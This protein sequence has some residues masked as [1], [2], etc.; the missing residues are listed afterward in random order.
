VKFGLFYEHQLP[1]P[2]T[3]DAEH[4]LLK[5]A[6][7]QVELADQLGF[8]Q[9][10]EVEHHFLEEYSHSSAPE[11]FLAAASQRTSRIRLGH[12][13]IQTPPPFNHPARVA[14]RV[15]TLDLL[16]D[17]RV[18][19]G[20]GESS[21]EAEL[22]G[23]G[24]HPMD[25]RDMWREG[26]DVAV[27]CLTE[28]PFT[29]HHGKHVQMPPRNVVPKPMQKPHPPLW[30]ACSR[31]DTIRLAAELGIGA[32][33]F[34][35]IDPEDAAH[36]ATEYEQILADRCVPAGLA[37]NHQLACVT[38]MMIHD[39]AE[40]A[41]RRGLEGG[42]FFGYSLGHYYIFGEHH[43]GR[44][45]VWAQFQERRA[46]HGFSPDIEAAIAQERLGAKAI[47][48]DGATGLRGAIG[49]VGQVRDYVRRYEEAGVDQIIFV[50]QSGKNRHD[51]ICE[52]LE[53]FATEV[54]PEFAERDEAFVKAKT[55]RLGPVVEAAMARRAELDPP[56]AL[57]P[58]YVMSG[59]LSAMA[60]ADTSGQMAE[61]NEQLAEDRALG[62]PLNIPGV[63]D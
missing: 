18:D 31:R 14:E 4:Q 58:D 25:K 15:A 50:L 21:S 2:W 3:D 49:D 42:N 9:V 35:F 34:S 24:I 8:D 62:K 41:I 10:W 22:G 45:D 6:L 16:S 38:P 36:W 52:S 57:D 47:D 20:T 43:P 30:V 26:L 60:K 33:A 53:L 61:L 56:P 59:M 17:G 12:G 63:F 37:V 27:R 51:H 28:T 11:V 13:I 46:Q 44:T 19:F 32:L 54:M 48:R 7:D 55:E 40:E 29:G 39:D 23:F 5:D 1:R